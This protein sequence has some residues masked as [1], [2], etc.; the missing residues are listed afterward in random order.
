MATTAEQIETLNPGDYIDAVDIYYRVI[1]LNTKKKKIILTHAFMRGSRADGMWT[2]YYTDNIS[3]KDF[4]YWG[5][6]RKNS[7]DAKGIEGKIK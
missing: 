6:I 4:Q 2:C 7:P 5:I 1:K 3:R